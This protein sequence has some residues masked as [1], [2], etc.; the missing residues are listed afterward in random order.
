MGHTFVSRDIMAMFKDSLKEH[1]DLMRQTHEEEVVELT[2]D[3]QNLMIHPTPTG[4][5][6]TPQGSNPSLRNATTRS[7]NAL[8]GAAG[9]DGELGTFIPQKGPF[10]LPI[11]QD[12]IP[13]GFKMLVKIS[14]YE[15]KTDQNVHL[16]AFNAAIH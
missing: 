9:F 7:P 1:T 12:I 3:M 8:P 4:G 11:Q 16:R 2:R 5:D 6:G 15:P 10:S 14:P 13:Q